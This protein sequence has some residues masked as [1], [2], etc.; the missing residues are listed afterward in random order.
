MHMNMLKQRIVGEPI[1]R[2]EVYTQPITFAVPLVLL[3]PRAEAFGEAIATH[4]IPRETHREHILDDRHVQGALKLQHIVVADLGIDIAAELVA[5]LD[6]REQHRAAGAA[7][8]EQ[9]PLRAL[10]SEEH[11]SELQSLMR[12][13]YAVFCLKKTTTQVVNIT[14]RS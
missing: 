10:R 2:G 11:T 6:R 12:T 3:L 5:R 1:G 14:T 7:F 8:T 4:N 13:S 9:R